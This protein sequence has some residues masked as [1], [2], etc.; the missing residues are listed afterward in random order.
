MFKGLKM[1]TIKSLQPVSRG[2]PEEPLFVK[3]QVVD[4]IDTKAVFG[5]IFDQGVLPLAE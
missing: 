5:G 4:G 3:K 2:N 1:I